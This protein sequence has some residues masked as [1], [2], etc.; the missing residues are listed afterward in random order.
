MPHGSIFEE[1]T[2]GTLRPGKR[3]DLV[4]LSADPLAVP[5]EALRE[6]Q[7]LETVQAG[8]TIYTQ[9]GKGGCKA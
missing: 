3:A 6:I 1:D 4:V 9:E 8:E 5:P 7:V 2:K